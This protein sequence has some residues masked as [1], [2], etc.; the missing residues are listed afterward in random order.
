MRTDMTVAALSVAAALA[1]S[2]CH[3]R[4]ACA[5]A[6]NVG[7]IEGT[8]T[9]SI[10]VRPLAG[11]RVLAIGTGANANVRGATTS[12]S[13]GRYR[14]DS[15]AAGRYMLGLESPLL[16]SLEI[17]LPPREAVV[18]AGGAAVVHLA[19]PPAAKLRAA[20]CPGVALPAGTGAIFGHVVSA[21]TEGPA[22]GIV[23][24]IQWRELNVD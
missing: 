15:L 1:L 19:L 24:A 12:D 10:H 7:R 21:E 5:Q 16:D 22:P 14:I 2:P 4:S 9:D 18:A 13:A 23:V 6:A 8:V 17:A 20:V 11:V 3:A